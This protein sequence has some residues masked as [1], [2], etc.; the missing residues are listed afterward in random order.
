MCSNN[1]VIARTRGEGG[2]KVPILSGRPLWLAPK[3]EFRK[4]ESFLKR[5]AVTYLLEN[6]GPSWPLLSIFNQMVCHVW[7]EMELITVDIK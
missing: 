2:Q 7:N 3:A 5:L 1:D 6:V 4:E